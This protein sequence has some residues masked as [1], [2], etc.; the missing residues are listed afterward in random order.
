[1]TAYPLRHDF[2]ASGNRRR[3]YKEEIESALRTRHM[4]GFQLLGLNDFPGQGT[5]L[6]GVLNPFW[7]EKAYIT[8]EQFRR[9]CAPSVVLARMAKRVFSSDENFEA[10]LEVAHYG[11]MPLANVTPYWRLQA[12]GAH[13][14]DGTVTPRDIAHGGGQEF[15]TLSVPLKDVRQATAC[16]LTGGVQLADGRVIENDWDFG[17]IQ[18]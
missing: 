8:A 10:R 5:A 11:E 3:V 18:R 6:V 16:K 1:M 7:R 14:A 2:M 12:N 17:S 9:F 15:A 4:G 13:L